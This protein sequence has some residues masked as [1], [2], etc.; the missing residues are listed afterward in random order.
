MAGTSQNSPLN[1]L[2]FGE[3]NAVLDPGII[4]GPNRDAHRLDTYYKL[5]EANI[6]GIFNRHVRVFT[7]KA[8]GSVV[9]TGDVTV[10]GTIFAQ[11]I[12]SPHMS[13]STWIWDHKLG[14]KPITI[15]IADGDPSQLLAP[16]EHVS[17]NQIRIQHTA[18]YN[19]YIYAR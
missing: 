11:P 17:D 18:S 1:V 16:V 8:D 13:G 4:D 15:V 10:P 2:T 6:L 7:L 5:N 14:Y 9:F 3:A 19:G 12:K